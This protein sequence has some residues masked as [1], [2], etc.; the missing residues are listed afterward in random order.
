[1]GGGGGK[2]REREGREGGREGGKEGEWRRVESRGRRRDTG[3]EGGKIGGGGIK[4]SKS[5]LLHVYYVHVC[6][7]V[8]TLQLFINRQ[9]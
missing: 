6:I 9:P 3:K 5:T 7:S 8:W 1:M 2:E 4:I